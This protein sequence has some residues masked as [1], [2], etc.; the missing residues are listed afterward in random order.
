MPVSTEPCKRNTIPVIDPPPAADARP[1]IAN[2]VLIGVG[3]GIFFPENANRTG[4]G[5]D[6]RLVLRFPDFVPTR[7]KEEAE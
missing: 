2:Q 7:G 3:Y 5:K 4:H 1:Y 6:Q